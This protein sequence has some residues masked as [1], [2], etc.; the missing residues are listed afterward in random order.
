MQQVTFFYSI[1]FKFIIFVSALIV[2]IMALVNSVFLVRERGMIE[3][4]IKSESFLLLDIVINSSEDFILKQNSSALQAII[5]KIKKEK[6]I[7][8]IQIYL[9]DTK[10]CLVHL[11]DSEKQQ[12]MGKKDKEEIDQL[13]R[14]PKP[15]SKRIDYKGNIYIDV[16]KNIMQDNKPY[17][18]ISLGMSLE[19]MG[20]ELKMTNYYVLII[21]IAAIIIGLIVAVFLANITLNP[22]EKLLSIVKL[23]SIGEFSQKV[24]V[25]TKDE[26]GVLSGTFNKMS[27]NIATLYHVTS[28][29][30]FMNDT[31]HLLSLILNKALIA[32]KSDHGSLMLLDEEA[33]YLQVKVVCGLKNEPKSFVRIPV[34]EGIAGTVAKI[35]VPMIINSGFHDDRFKIFRPDPADEKSIKSLLCVPLKSDE[36]IFGVINIINKKDSVFEKDDCQFLSV[37]ASQ[38]AISLAKAKLYEDSITDGLTKLYI[39][40]YFQNR[41]LEEIKRALRYNSNVSL[42][43]IDLDHFKNLND[44][45]GHQQGDIILATTSA[46]IKDSIRENIDIACRYG[47]EELSVIMPETDTVGAQKVA[48]RLR[49]KIESQMYSVNNNNL[50]ITVSMGIATFPEHLIKK[51]DPEEKDILLKKSDAEK[52]DGLIKKADEALYLAKACGRNRVVL[53]SELPF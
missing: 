31:E 1:R 42:L 52:K 34:G 44:T 24:S 20:R 11:S 43:M 38:A 33:K 45:Y 26:F 25:K 13:L 22:L 36:K 35:G 7:S 51:E 50:S 49:V 6:N 16:S 2:L 8:Y 19:N 9:A 23:M 53:A 46:I 30:S 47:G 5:N 21:G 15:V 39:H 41:L 48:D 14:T 29:M 4:R 32:L 37:L 3:E 18:L 17:A 12:S 28:A 40:R 27:T 10:Q